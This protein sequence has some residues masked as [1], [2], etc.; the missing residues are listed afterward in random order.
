MINSRA[1]KH[2]WDLG[3]VYESDIMSRISRGHY[4]RTG[5]KRITGDTVEI[6]ECTDFEFYDLFWY[7]NTPNEWEN[8]KHRRWLGV[9]HHIGS[10]LC[11]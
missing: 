7:C 11:Y 8:P 9:S 4:V 3:M 6:S 10:S 1:P 5:M 2:V